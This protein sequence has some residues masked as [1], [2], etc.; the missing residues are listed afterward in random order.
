MNANQQAIPVALG[1]QRLRLPRGMT[2]VIAMMYL[3]LISSLAVGFYAATTTSTRVASNDERVTRAQFAA[4]SG[5]D[6]MRRQMAKVKVP[7]GVAPDHS[8][9]YYYPNLQSQLNG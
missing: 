3:V 8:I 2:S 4:S 5:M 6:F 1:R 7:P 9:D